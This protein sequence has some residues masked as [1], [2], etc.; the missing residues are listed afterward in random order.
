MQERS[1]CE[2]L[3]VSDFT[4]DDVVL[5]MPGNRIYMFP[6]P[7]SGERQLVISEECARH[8][9]PPQLMVVSAIEDGEVMGVPL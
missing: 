6:A 5:V 1:R 3:A 2:L 4:H 9:R 7:K 8:L